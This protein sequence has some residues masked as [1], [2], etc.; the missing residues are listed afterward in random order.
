METTISMLKSFGSHYEIL[1]E[2][3]SS[4]YVLLGKTSR[5]GFAC[6][7]DFGAGCHLVRLTDKFWNKEKLVHVL[8]AVDG[9]AVAEALYSLG[10]RGVIPENLTSPGRFY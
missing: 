10:K 7:P 8:G 1:I 2:G 5:G 3:R 9:A 4:I 6:M